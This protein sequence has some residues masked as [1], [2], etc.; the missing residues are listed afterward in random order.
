MPCQKE[1]EPFCAG[2]HEGAGGNAVKDIGVGVNVL[3]TLCATSVS[4]AGIS[5]G[6][7]LVMVEV[8]NKNCTTGVAVLQIRGGGFVGGGGGRGVFVGGRGV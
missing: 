3:D 6:G 1:A 4:D 7:K 5:T 8:G 2:V